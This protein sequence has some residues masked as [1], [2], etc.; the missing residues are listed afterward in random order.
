MHK[1]GDIAYILLGV[2]VVAG[3]IAAIAL[4]PGLGAALKLIDPNP[5]KAVAKAD[6]ALR[7]LVKSN[8]VILTKKGYVLTTKGE[9]DY[10]RGQFD[11]YTFPTPR[12][13]DKKWRV[14]C[15]DVPEKKKHVRRLLHD[16]L[17]T[18][19]CYRL[20]DS[21]FV[22][23]YSCAEFLKVAHGAYGLSDYVRGMVVTDIDKKEA[24]H[25]FFRLPV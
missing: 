22:T 2:L 13:W 5:R 20:Q 15:F 7:S 3:V 11:R 17:K 24:L 23:P 1:K 18:L 6:R 8:K 21:V 9:Q 12:T 25:S 19:G 4:A 16:K 10:L 14:I